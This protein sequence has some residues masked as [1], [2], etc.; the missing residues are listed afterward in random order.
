MTLSRIQEKFSQ[1]QAQK[2][3]ALITYI[4]AYAPD[5]QTSQAVLN[6]LPEAGAD[7]IE[8][9][10]PFSDPM[11]D[12]PT[13]Q[14]AAYA[15]L[16]A[17]GTLKGVL[18]MVAHF[19]KN[20]QGTPLILMGYYNPLQNYGLEKFTSD[21]AQAGVDGLLIVDL[22]PEEEKDLKD[23]CEKSALAWVRLIAP[24]SDEARIKTIVKSAS[25][26]IYYV[27]VA[28]VTGTK[29]AS[30]TSIESAVAKIKKHTKLPVAVGFGIKS[31]ADVAGVAKSADGVV[32]GS[33][34]VKNISQNGAAK[35]LALV[36]DL[37]AGVKPR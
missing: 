24:T 28:G 25:G 30:S 12:G 18:A 29:S 3:A 9:G 36:K 14:E 23:A 2:R 22:P 1:T 8:L 31:S 10:L 26:F 17:G 7:I 34:I 6:G 19:R 32:V 11:A 5:L 16:Q 20:N 35:T 4:M 33:A 27:A 13:I 15:A 21:A 37:A